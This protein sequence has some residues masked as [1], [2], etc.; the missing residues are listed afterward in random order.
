MTIEALEKLLAEYSE[1]YGAFNQDPKTW[2]AS[3]GPWPE[4]EHLEKSLVLQEMGEIMKLLH[5]KTRD[6]GSLDTQ[7]D[8]E[9]YSTVRQALSIIHEFLQ[10]HTQS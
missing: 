2:E 9:Y 4:Y 8:L 1:K 10:K 6:E 5:L 7:G 3:N